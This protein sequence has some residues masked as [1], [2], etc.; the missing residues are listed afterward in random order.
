M[1][2]KKPLP[3]HKDKLGRILKV[4][5]CVCYP[6]RNSLEFGKVIKLNAKMIG[7]AELP[8]SK[9]GSY[10]SNKYPNDTVLVDGP[11]VTMYLIKNST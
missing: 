6:A 10:Y 9:Y 1:A 4:G 5:D 3:E 11:E 7:I 2:T 8:A